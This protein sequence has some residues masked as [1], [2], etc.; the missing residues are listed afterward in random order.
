V[1]FLGL[2]SSPLPYLLLAA[3]YFFGFAMGMFNN[4]T[5][6][7]S[8]ETVSAVTIPAEVR[9]KPIETAVFFYQVNSEINHNQITNCQSSDKSSTF[10]PD[11]KKEVLRSQNHS[12]P[13]FFV[14]GFRFSRPPPAHC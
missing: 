1:F 14:N 13:E 6:D 2:L 12:V 4:S 10:P 8:T 11:I 5:G 3:F 7:E 9:Q